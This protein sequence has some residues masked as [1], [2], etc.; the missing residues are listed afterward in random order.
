MTFLWEPSRYP[1]DLSIL[2]WQLLDSQPIALFVHPKQAR[3]SLCKNRSEPPWPRCAGRM[4]RVFTLLGPGLS[5]ALP[6]VLGAR[7]E[8]L[9]CQG[10]LCD[11]AGGK[12][13]GAALKK[14]P[15]GTSVLEL[16]KRDLSC[17]QCRSSVAQRKKIH[18]EKHSA[19]L[20][21]TPPDLGDGSGPC[22]AR[23]FTMGGDE[24]SGAPGTVQVSLQARRLL[25]GGQMTGGRW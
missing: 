12:K 16:W 1:R 22:E 7:G 17:C 24:L 25:D 19:R 15:A 21:A 14:I 18:L 3:T 5:A 10:L 4:W 11:A 8:K 13:P 23:S 2:Q 6:S 20:Q 9:G